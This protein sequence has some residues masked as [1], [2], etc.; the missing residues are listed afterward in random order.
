[1][2]GLLQLLKINQPNYA[3]INESVNACKDLNLTWAKKLINGV[4]RNILRNIDAIEL[5]F[6]K[7]SK[8]DLPQ[9]LIETI[10]QQCPK[11]LLK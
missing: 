1:M 4:L 6:N 3:S 2:L 8:V 5:K 11:N 10:K 9:W 7:Y